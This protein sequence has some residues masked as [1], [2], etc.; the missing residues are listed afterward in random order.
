M[1]L[2]LL[3]TSPTLLGTSVTFNT[4][5]SYYNYNT[6]ILVMYLNKD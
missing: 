5:V 3:G 4:N 1:A 6:I 2:T